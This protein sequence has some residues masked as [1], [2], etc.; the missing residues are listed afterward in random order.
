MSRVVEILELPIDHLIPDDP[1]IVNA[2]VNLGIPSACLLAKR[3]EQCAVIVSFGR[4]T[5]RRTPCGG[6][7]RPNDW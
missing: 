3:R 6:R 1:A 4:I 7:H 5:N 2:S